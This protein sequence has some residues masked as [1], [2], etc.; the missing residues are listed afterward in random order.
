MIVC[1]Y[2]CIYIIGKQGNLSIRERVLL[3]LN[4]EINIKY[5]FQ[6]V[7]LGFVAHQR[8]RQ[9]KKKTKKKLDTC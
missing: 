9:E 6:D 4:L 2:M 7:A 5:G 3:W 8:Q 1:I